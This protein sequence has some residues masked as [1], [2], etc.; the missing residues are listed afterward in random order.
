MFPGPYETPPSQPEAGVPLLRSREV[1]IH[2][3]QDMPGFYT[4]N[5]NISHSY[6]Q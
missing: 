1:R 3:I 5:N 2:Y 4:T 6:Y